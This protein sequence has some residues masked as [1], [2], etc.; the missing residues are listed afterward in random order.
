MGVKDNGFYLTIAGTM[1]AV[2]HEIVPVDSVRLD[3]DNPRIRLVAQRRFKGRV[4]K[5]DE[6]MELVKE[7]PAYDKL[8]K[9]IRNAGGIHDPVIVSHDGRVVEGNCR[10]V[11]H[12]ALKALPNAPAKWAS[13]P[14][15]RLPKDIDPKLL[16]L[17]T[18][19]HHIG[20][21]TQWS[22]YAQAAHI[23]HLAKVDKI[24][25]E[26][27]AAETRMGMKKAQHYL[28][29]YAFLN[30]EV[31][32][33][34][35]EGDGEG[36]DRKWSHAY[37]F[38]KDPDLEPYRDDPGNRSAVINLIVSNAIKGEEVRD[39]AKIF[40]NKK[41]S[42]SLKKE[43]FK[44][45]MAALRKADPVAGSK[46]LQNIEKMTSV[47]KNLQRDELALFDEKKAKDVLRALHAE[48]VGLAEIKKVEL[49]DGNG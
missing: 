25:L 12:M 41:A 29:T 26:Q 44:P 15:V 1:V 24:P 40:G 11:V 35:G 3:P 38:I 5:P 22:P 39:L 4:P 9:A 2:S 36:L 17:L 45:A 28:D 42:A 8:F 27:I 32:K 13:I 10:T 14:V 34:K 19:S 20:R 31:A 30:K 43:G 18:A 49:G 33:A 6:V 16:G 47:L 21:K 48:V 37:E 46:L 7:Q 23:H